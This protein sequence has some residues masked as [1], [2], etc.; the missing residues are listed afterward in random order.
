MQ[1]TPLVTK[2]TDPISLTTTAAHS[3]QTLSSLVSCLLAPDEAAQLLAHGGLW[4]NGRRTLETAQPVTPGMHLMLHR[5][6]GGR[7]REVTIEAS[8]IHDEDRW[9]LVLNKRAGW[10]TSPTPWDIHGNIQAA[11]R[12]FLRERDGH[13]VRPHLA[14]QLD[15]DTSGLLICTRNRELN[16]PLQEAFSSG[17]VDKTY[18]AICAGE[19]A[20]DQFE[21]Q[22]GHG[23]RRGG[24][25]I[26]PLEHLG[27][28]LP[29]NKPV[30]LA[31][32]SFV[33]EQRMGDAALLRATLHTGRTHQIRLH[34]AEIGHPLLGDTRYGGPDT[35]HGQELRF[36]MLHAARLRLLHPVT[37]ELLD[38]EAP[39]PVHMAAVL[40]T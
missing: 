26:Y 1:D 16:G 9:L 34:L 36:H 13:D 39:L 31:H 19:P 33:V 20:P 18:R 21:M 24:W 6:P 35:Y 4:L 10:H 17:S 38:L 8:D 11:L 27:H 23:R 32:T 29:N 25:Q 14:H 40:P 2:N 5:P 37:G 22:T 3:G 12:R 7:Y 15:R 30:K 28:M